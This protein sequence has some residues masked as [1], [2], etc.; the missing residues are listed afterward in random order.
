M[1]KAAVGEGVIKL[2]F[3]RTLGTSF[4]P[5]VAASFLETKP[6]KSIQF[7]F[8]SSITG[9]LLEGLK[10][11]KYDV[12]FCTKIEQEAEIEFIPVEKQDLVLIVLEIILWQITTALTSQKPSPTLR[13]IFQRVLVCVPSLTNYLKKLMES[14]PL[15]TKSRKTRLS[16]VWFPKGSALLLCHTW[17]SYCV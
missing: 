8:F 1:Q 14:L 10:Q 11:D 3:L 7:E 9:P 2:G 13:S 15:P 5:E 17:S 16:Q 6:D 4:I 12:V